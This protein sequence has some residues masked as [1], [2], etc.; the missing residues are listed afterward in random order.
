MGAAPRG[1]P[2]RG[3]CERGVRA[4]PGLGKVL[5]GLT[6]RRMA[7]SWHHAR[8]FWRTAVPAS[9]ESAMQVV[10]GVVRSAEPVGRSRRYAA[11]NGPLESGEQL[12]IRTEQVIA[13]S[14]LVSLAHL[15]A[16]HG[17]RLS[18]CRPGESRGRRRCALARRGPRIAASR[19]RAA[20]SCPPSPPP[21]GTSTP[22]RR[23]TTPQ[24]T[25][26][27]KS[28]SAQDARE[29][30]SQSRAVGRRRLPD[31][32]LTRRRR[33]TDARRRPQRPLARWLP[34]LA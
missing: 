8:T 33:R 1:Q 30:V 6:R 10:R 20:R 7:Q 31:R 17:R 34:D 12:L 4:V 24:S 9:N 19:G 16:T 22:S 18:R 15:S 3:R 14:R 26:L 5:P 32:S 23:Q 29:S 2:C 27:R 11:R 28:A 13:A 25:R 21:S